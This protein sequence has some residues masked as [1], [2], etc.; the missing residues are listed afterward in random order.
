M[1]MRRDHPTLVGISADT[2]G[3]LY[4]NGKYRYGTKNR[5]GYKQHKINYITYLEHRLVAECFIGRKLDTEEHINHKNS[6]RDDN[7]VENLEVGS[8]ED[9]VR[10]RWRKSPED[11]KHVC[12]EVERPN[13]SGEKNGMSKLT[14]E[15]VKSMILGFKDGLTNQ[16]ASDKY[17]VHPRYVSLIRHRKR[18]KSVWVEMGLSGSTTIPSG[19]RASS[20]WKLET[21]TSL[22]LRDMI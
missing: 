22:Q 12:M 2:E 14:K 6:I 18:W 10:H 1:H 20:L 4:R 11:I 17:G 16:E 8:S 21:E 15:Q 7:R 9:N 13:S 3:N 5:Q 19:S